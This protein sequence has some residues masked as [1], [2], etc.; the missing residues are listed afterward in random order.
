MAIPTKTKIILMNSLDPSD[1]EDGTN[2]EDAVPSD[3]TLAAAAPV[4]E[5]GPT[6]MIRAIAT[7][8]TIKFDNEA[9]PADVRALA[10]AHLAAL[11]TPDDSSVMA[12]ASGTVPIV[13]RID[14]IASSEKERSGLPPWVSVAA[15]AAVFLGVTG[16]VLA[17]SSLFR[18]SGAR[19]PAVTAPVAAAPAA[20]VSPVVERAPAPAHNPVA[21]APPPPV[22]ESLPAPAAGAPIVAAAT[23]AEPEPVEINIA[24]PAIAL[25]PKR[26]DDGKTAS[27]A[28]QGTR[29]AEAAPR[30]ESA[31]KK[32]RA[33]TPAPVAAKPRAATPPKP[34][35]AAPAAPP[36]PKSAEVDDFARLS[37]LAKQQLGET[38]P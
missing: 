21:A 12:V 38:L 10:S 25:E 31:A 22:A 24:P 7:P 26:V 37:G 23:V 1:V 15:A 34:V 35:A 33:P 4:G 9:V 2:V 29:V 11:K 28:R 32:E 6:N 3:A 17:K 27:R 5:D 13:R 8:P 30:A 18:A 14:R 19:T 36:A 20:A 16:T